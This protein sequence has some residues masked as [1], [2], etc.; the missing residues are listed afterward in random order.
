MQP[1]VA[2]LTVGTIDRFYG[3][4]VYTQTKRD[5][6]DL[7]SFERIHSASLCIQHETDLLTVWTIK[8]IYCARMCRH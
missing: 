6:V 5:K 3:A 8:H 1:E 7:L 4:G 2:L